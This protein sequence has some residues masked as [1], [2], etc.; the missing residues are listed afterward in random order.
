MKNRAVVAVAVIALVVIAVTVAV[1][2]PDWFADTSTAVAGHLGLKNKSAQAKIG[3]DSESLSEGRLGEERGAADAGQGENDQLLQ[4]LGSLERPAITTLLTENPPS[5]TIGQLSGIW[6]SNAAY[7]I[8]MPEGDYEIYL[9]GGDSVSEGGRWSV[10]GRQITFSPL[11]GASFSTPF[12]Y[13]QTTKTDEP[14]NKWFAFN[15]NIALRTIGFGACGRY[16]TTSEAETFNAWN[17]NQICQSAYGYNYQ[18]MLNDPVC[19][20]AVP[21]LYQSGIPNCD[22]YFEGFSF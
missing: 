13:Q 3:T 12:E 2:F 14:Y 15:Y 7:M 22:I 18:E 4:Q 9:G 1:L 21:V 6:R 19:R 20:H 8:L 11:D 16:D 5:G 10:Q 17:F